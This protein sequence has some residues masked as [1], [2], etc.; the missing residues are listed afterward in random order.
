MAAA[1]LALLDGGAGLDEV[2]AGA[3]VV[4]ATGALLAAAVEVGELRSMLTRLEVDGGA[5]AG[6]ALQVE[7]EAEV[8][9]A[10]AQL[11]STKEGRTCSEPGS[12]PPGC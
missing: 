11:E 7:D 5:A 10:R 4:V 2:A 6:E 3:E 1:L 8:S 9:G 12:A